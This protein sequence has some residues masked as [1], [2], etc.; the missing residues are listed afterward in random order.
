MILP[1]DDEEEALENVPVIL[2]IDDDEEEALDGQPKIFPFDDEEEVHD[3]PPKILPLDDEGKALD[4]VP[5]ALPV[6]DDEEEALDGQPDPPEV[7]PFNLDEEEALDGPPMILPLDDEEEALENV[8][9]ILPIDD[10][11]E[12][13]L[14]GQPKIFPFDDEE[15]VHDGPPKILPLDDEG[16]ALDDVPMALPVD[17]DEKEALDGQ[18]EMI[19]FDSEEALD[20][21]LE[22]LPLGKE[23]EALD[24]PPDVLQLGDE[25]AASDLL[26]IERNQT[27]LMN[28]TVTNSNTQSQESC[29]AREEP[30]DVPPEIL[31]LS[32]GEEVQDGP[33]TLPIEH[34]EQVLNTGEPKSDD[35]EAMTLRGG[36]GEEMN[37]DEDDEFSYDAPIFH[38]SHFH[39]EFNDLVRQSSTAGSA[40]DDSQ[41]N[42]FSDTSSFR[43]HNSSVRE[44]QGMSVDSSFRNQGSS[45]Y[46]NESKRVDRGRVGS[47]SSRSNPF[48]LDDSNK[49]G[50]SSVSGQSNHG[51]SGGTSEENMYQFDQSGTSG[52]TESDIFQSQTSGI[53]GIPGYNASSNIHY[54]YN[55]G[56]NAA[57]FREPRVNSTLHNI[58]EFD[59]REARPRMDEVDESG[60]SGLTESD[61][62]QSQRSGSEFD[63]QGGYSGATP[64]VFAY[65]DDGQTESKNNME[66]SSGYGTNG[67]Y[68]NGTN[69][70]KDNANSFGQGLD[71][72][73]PRHDHRRQFSDSGYSFDQSSKRQSDIANEWA[74]P[75][76]AQ[77]S[78]GSDA[79]SFMDSRRS[80]ALSFSRSMGGHSIGERFQEGW[81]NIP[82]GSEYLPEN[83]HFPHEPHENFPEP[84]HH[85]S[86]SDQY[87]PQPDRP[88]PEPEAP[89][90]FQI[91]DEEQEAKYPDFPQ[92]S[93]TLPMNDNGSQSSSRSQE[94]E[95][96]F[97]FQEPRLSMTSRD[98]FNYSDPVEGEVCALA[99][100]KVIKILRYFSRV[101]SA[102]EPLAQQSGL[103]DALLYHMTKKPHSVDFEDEIAS[104]VDAIAV[105][106]NLACA[107]ENKIM[108][109]YHP[110]LLDAVINI[111]NHDPIDEARE[112]AAIVLMNLAYAEENKVHMVNQENLLN[113]LVHLL[114][115]VSPFTR[116]YAS[117]ALFT[118]A[119][120]YANTAVM[121]RHCDGG[122][123]EALRKVLLNDPIDE[124]RVN[125]A[126]ALFNMARNNSDD[127]VSNMGNHPRLLASLA[128]SVLTDYSADVRAY[129]AR[130]LEWLSADI[131]HPM[132]CHRILLRAL[133][134][135]SQWTKTTC[136]A[137]A[138]K[139]QASLS[140]NRQPMVEHP[141][142]LDALANLSLLNGISDDEVK[143]C[144]ISA[145]ERLSK[146]EKTRH[147][148]VKNEGVM[149]ALTKATFANDGAEEDVPE[150]GMP[151]ALLMKTALKNLAEHMI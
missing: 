31:P 39:S 98:Y 93:E 66:Q 107:E 127:T 1:L 58:A 135:S 55:Q 41:D 19:P 141:G 45:N 53:S 125:A 95:D 13:A 74:A 59:E 27:N 34:R 47:G 109:V 116:R 149:T 63:E 32:D 30:P 9:V 33:E 28:Q 121:A 120:T 35:E 96:I 12:E 138:L 97:Q 56:A 132:P 8:P 110:G 26:N 51:R 150:E 114:S 29:L 87:F 11:E 131:H 54:E 68:S 136:I 122:I 84:N 142:L 43:N 82:E 89:D 36:G 62:Y 16:E 71:S 103:V 100:R 86:E 129:S 46:G 128:H 24:G 148:M 70:D 20:G 134:T 118:L 146:E 2:P 78:R 75:S 81:N 14:D 90:Q 147:I 126:E 115:D 57:S 67:S 79:Q 102:M 17:G 21:R 50:N 25:V 130:A 76:D 140:E 85:Y 10:D 111:A 88:F 7:V 112:H 143:T 77:S 40:Y 73:D 61:I 52:L 92:K 101:L 65:G 69:Q 124:A 144:A 44:G 94:P 139:M 83:N 108:L 91:D 72:G 23:E 104:R 18:P 117:A 133:T 3:G 137:E 4:D 15:E 123:L 64:A 48:F 37:N 99:I 38:P 60:R 80:E 42:P 113:T 5:M 49:D 6:D 151:T 145:L 119:C 105:V 22:I 106:V